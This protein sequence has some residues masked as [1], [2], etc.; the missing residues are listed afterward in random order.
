MC[1]CDTVK[2]WPLVLKKKTRA[3]PHFLVRAV[4]ALA[5]Y[6]SVNRRQTHKWLSHRIS[7]NIRNW[8]TV[9]QKMTNFH[10]TVFL[11]FD[12]QG[13]TH[14][15]TEHEVALLKNAN[16]F[17]RMSI[18]FLLINKRQI[19]LSLSIYRV[20]FIRI[21]YLHWRCD[22]VRKSNRFVVVSSLLKHVT[23]HLSHT[24]THTHITNITFSCKL[25]SCLTS[26]I[27]IK[28]CVWRPF[29]VESLCVCAWFTFP[30]DF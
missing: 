22:N 19:S 27:Q 8:A 11:I 28:S 15:H 12:D 30:P 16:E 9:Q 25:W 4:S 13:H 26:L 23:Q 20:W 3:Y 6:L 14:L 29:I 24:Y 10:L 1:V 5:H 7:S 17:P 21:L 2:K 18:V